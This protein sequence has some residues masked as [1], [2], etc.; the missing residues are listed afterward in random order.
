[1]S[2]EQ[3]KDEAPVARWIVLVGGVV[4]IKAYNMTGVGE[5]VQEASGTTNEEIEVYS[6]H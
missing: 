6:I 4:Q 5:F 2:E 3:Q 1:M